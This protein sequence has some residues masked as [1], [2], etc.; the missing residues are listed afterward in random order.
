MTGDV[1][2]INVVCVLYIDRKDDDMSFIY[3]ALFKMF[4][5]VVFDGYRTGMLLE[6]QR[7]PYSLNVLH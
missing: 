7:L 4:I 1:N 2:N 5:C 3:V 6:K